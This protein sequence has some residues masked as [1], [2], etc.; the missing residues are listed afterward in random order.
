MAHHAFAQEETEVIESDS[1]PSAY[2]IESYF[3]QRAFRMIVPSGWEVTNQGKEN[4]PLEILSP[5]IEDDVYQGNIKIMRFNE[6]IRIS[7]QT[8]KKY[9]DKITTRHN[10]LS[11]IKNFSIRNYDET[12]LNDGT[13]VIIIYS[14][15][16][17]DK[18]DLMQA[19]VLIPAAKSHY[20]LTYTDLQDR[21]EGVQKEVFTDTVWNSLISFK[22]S[23]PVPTNSGQLK[24]WLTYT[25]AK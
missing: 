19:H 24:F 13:K 17:I 15:F 4:E 2:G 23:N 20:L 7:E 22:P 18:T 5:K 3:E 12:T 1:S 6:S 10:F 9:E 14:E 16:K 21:F 25:L 8:A 11:Y